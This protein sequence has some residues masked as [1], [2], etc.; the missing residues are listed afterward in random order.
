[1]LACAE[2]ISLVEANARRMRDA[3]FIPFHFLPKFETK[4]FF[5]SESTDFPFL[6]IRNFPE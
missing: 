6:S 4:I 3:L 2:M 5:T 1:M